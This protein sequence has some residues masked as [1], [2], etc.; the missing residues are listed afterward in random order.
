[1]QAYFVLILLLKYLIGLFFVWKPEFHSKFSKQ[2]NPEKEKPKKA[3]KAKKKLHRTFFI[4]KVFKRKNVSLSFK[5]CGVSAKNLMK[6]LLGDLWWS[7][8]FFCELK[9]KKYKRGRML[10]AGLFGM[11]KVIVMRFYEWKKNLFY[12]FIDA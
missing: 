10:Q 1:M 4:I 9:R 3:A 7:S 8:T 2:S 11:D 6:Y 12:F 5:S